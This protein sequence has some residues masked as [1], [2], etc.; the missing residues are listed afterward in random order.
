MRFVRVISSGAVLRGVFV[1]LPC[2][3]APADSCGRDRAFDGNFG[4]G[5]SPSMGPCG[6]MAGPAA[7]GTTTQLAV[8]CIV[9]VLFCVVMCCV[10]YCV[11][12][13]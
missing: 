2:V 13:R 8:V 1:V 9:C 11:A 3:F 7:V 5:L 12:P 6:I 4:E 10:V